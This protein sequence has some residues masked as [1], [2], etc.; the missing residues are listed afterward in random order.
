MKNFHKVER[1][2]RTN[3]QKKS[4]KIF[5]IW[6]S[7]F[8][9]GTIYFSSSTTAQSKTNIKPKAAAKPLPNLT[10]NTTNGQKWSLDE[11]RGRVV[12]LNFWATWCVP[13]RAEVPYLVRLSNKYKTGGLDVVGINIDGD[14]I[15]QINSFIKEFKVDYTVLLT[16][17]GSILTRQK[18]VP[19]S[20]LIDGKGV[21]VKKYVGAI[22]ESVFEKD[23]TDLLDRKSARTEDKWKGKVNE[24]F[25]QSGKNERRK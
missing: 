15:E 10:L 18:A 8:A 1:K 23:I 12:L 11:N 24:T 25:K 7:L 13:C 2:I 22:K 9:L 17:P 5:I 20:L 3:K 19:M 16:V 6:L 14:N 4:R 21:L